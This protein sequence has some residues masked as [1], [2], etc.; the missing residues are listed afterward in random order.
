MAADA[1]SGQNDIDKIQNFATSISIVIFTH[2]VGIKRCI[3]I[4]Q[5]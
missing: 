4:M 5:A 3:H 1:H 2:I